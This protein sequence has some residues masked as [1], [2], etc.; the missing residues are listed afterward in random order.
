[1][2]AVVVTVAWPGDVLRSHL[3]L[4]HRLTRARAWIP[5]EK[6]SLSSHEINLP[7]SKETKVLAAGGRAGHKEN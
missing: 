5:K 3:I 4:L 6:D 1:M 7:E 2:D